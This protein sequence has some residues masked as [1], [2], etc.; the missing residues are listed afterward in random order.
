M[1]L[2]ALQL[3]RAM[4]IGLVVYV[5][6]IDLQMAFSVSRQQNFFYLQDFGAIGVDL[7]F[8]VSGFI[9]TLVSS[10]YMGFREGRQFLVK[11]FLR[12]NPLYYLASLLLPGISIVIASVS[13]GPGPLRLPLSWHSFLQ[14]VFIFPLSTVPNKV[15]P[16][17]I[18]GWT[19]SFEWFFYGLLFVTI[20]IKSRYKPALLMMMIVLLVLIGRLAHF[21]NN[22]LLFMT[23]PILLEFTL[24]III[25]LVYTRIKR[26]P[27]LGAMVLV[28]A[29]LVI[30]SVEIFYGFDGV[31]NL[32]R[33]QD[34]SLG[35]LRFLV[36]G[37]PCGLLVAGCVFLEKE[38]VFTR[39]WKNKWIQ[40]AGDA[41]Y[42][43]YCTH[44][45]V[46]FLLTA[47]YRAVGFP[48][49]PDLLILLQVAVAMAAGIVFYRNVEKPLL[50]KLRY[51]HKQPSRSTQP[52][53]HELHT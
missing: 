49:M 1:K 31:A 36:W 20:I 44:P 18:V 28:L 37:L 11:R 21:T 50:R 35:L 16:L 4:A 3:L 25:C 29:T 19:L 14:T 52:V 24:G 39:L 33:I 7:F 27:R 51:K 42:S 23:N 47:L 30:F 32:L 2:N 53:A 10:Q 6:S 41:S 22:Q 34:G 8:V 38:A 13:H 12:I 46:F 43:I 15:F 26:F 17:L 9:I 48:G 40:L 45:I 5:H